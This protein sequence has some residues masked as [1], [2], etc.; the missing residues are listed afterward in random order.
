[1]SFKG[2][3]KA[4]V[5]Y[6]AEK[7]AARRKQRKR[8]EEAQRKAEEE[9]AGG[10]PQCGHRHMP[11]RLDEIFSGIE[12]ERQTTLSDRRVQ[13]CVSDADNPGP[14]MLRVRFAL[15]LLRPRFIRRTP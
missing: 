12:L 2:A 14:I 15:N 10:C 11:D 5:I 4:H 9:R 1:M 8:F 13:G 7:R 6:K 3:L